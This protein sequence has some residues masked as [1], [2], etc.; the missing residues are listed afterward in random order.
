M[1]GLLH[2]IGKLVLDQHFQVDWDRLLAVGQAHEWTLIE[3]EEHLLGLDHAQIGGH[4]GRKWNL[5]AC[6]VDTITSHHM[7]TYAHGAPKLAAIVHLADI[8]CLR[9][10]VGLAHAVFLPNPSREALRLLALDPSEVDRLA[11]QYSAI[12]DSSLAAVSV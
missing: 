1:G 2:D 5:P 3:A 10:G 4:L 11:E 12:L 8:I 9:L 7:P 6:L